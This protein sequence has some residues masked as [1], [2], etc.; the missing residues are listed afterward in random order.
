MLAKCAL[1]NSFKEASSSIR[2]PLG[3]SRDQIV[4]CILLPEATAWK[5]L[6]LESPWRAHLVLLFSC[7]VRWKC[8]K[9]LFLSALRLDKWEIFSLVRIPLE[10]PERIDSMANS[11][12][13][14]AESMLAVLTFIQLLV[15]DLSLR[16]VWQK[17]SMSKR[18]SASEVEDHQRWNHSM[19]SESSS[20]ERLNLKG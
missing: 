9:I 10:G 1:P 7:Q 15:A 2:L 13:E 8:S 18:L 16:R 19:K 4:F 17:S 20:H 12:L 5:N 3:Y 6:V 11:R 14:E